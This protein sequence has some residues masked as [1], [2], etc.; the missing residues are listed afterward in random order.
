MSGLGYV[1][2]F[3]PF[4]FIVWRHQ[5]KCD[6]MWVRGEIGG[7]QTGGYVVVHPFLQGRSEP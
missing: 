5:S 7:R 2:I 4:H 3:I 6:A 1:A